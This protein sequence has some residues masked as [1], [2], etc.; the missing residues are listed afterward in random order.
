[1]SI[2]TAY[3]ES[4]TAEQETSATADQE[5]RGSDV[6]SEIRGELKLAE[7][8]SKHTSWR[9]GGPADR[10]FKPADM[11]DLCRFISTLAAD[12][13]VTWVGLG[14]NL[15]V[16]D[17]GVRGT[18][19]ATSGMLNELTAVEDTLIRAEAGVSCAK[20][21]R[22][23]AN[24]DCTGAEFLAGIPGTIGGAL[25]MNAGAFS[26]ETWD[27]VEKVDML[28][29]DGKIL[30]RDAS[31]FDVGYRSVRGLNGCWFSAAYFRLQKGDVSGAKTKIRELLNKRNESQPTNLPN[32]GSVFRNPENDYSARLIEVCGLKG[33]RIGGAEVSQ[34]H[35]NF[36]INT[37]SATASDIES[38]IA[39]VHDTVLQQ[40][41]VDLI[42][43][44]RI[45]G[46]A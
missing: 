38:L 42:R 27:I 33:Y 24:L 41:G 45:I 26:G 43:E 29:R 4:A 28:S 30:Q 8:M 36:I 9:V 39:H 12:E 13:P 34:K 14:S 37:G 18:V 32:A 1:M 40:Q 25:A 3:Q 22:F 20:A 46:E 5:T 6:S 21:A 44:V 23:A 16:R 2:A 11:E 15:L 10:Y 7:P 19:I 17:G 31:E 35:A